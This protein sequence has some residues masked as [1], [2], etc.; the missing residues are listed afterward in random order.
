VTL[1]ATGRKIYNQAFKVD[2]APFWATQ[3]HPE[4]NKATTSERWN[5]YRSHYSGNEAEAAAI[6]QVMADAP[7]TLEVQAILRSFA[8]WVAANPR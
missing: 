3:F 5:Y 8:G 2:G 1:L 7:D 4:L 6:D